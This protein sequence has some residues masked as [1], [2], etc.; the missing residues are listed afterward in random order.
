MKFS[1]KTKLILFALLITLN[2]IL[3]YQLVHHETGIDSFEMHIL[4]NSISEFGEARWWTNPFAIVG[5]H[6][7]SYASAISFTISGIS[8]CSDIDIELSILVYSIIL[9]IFSIFA[10]YILA[11]MLYDD[12][13]FKF[14]IAFGFSTCQG[15]LTYSTWTAN[16]RS[17]FVIL[18]PLFLYALWQ[19]R[20]N[21]LRFGL[22]TVS[23]TLLLFTTHHLFVYLM[24]VF[25][26]YF[27]VVV[28]YELAKHIRF[29]KIPEELMPFLIIFA[30]CLMFAYPFI[31]HK[32][33]TADSRWV[34][35]TF[36]LNEYP[37]YIGILVFLLPGG[38][39]YLISKPNKQFEEWSLLVMLMFLTVFV[40]EERYMKWFIIIFVILLTGIGL[41]NLK[42]L[43]ERRKKCAAIAVTIFL[44]LSVCFSGYFQFLHTYRAE[45][46][47]DENSYITAL[48]TKGKM[49]GVGICNSR[50]RAWKITAISALPLLTGSSTADQAYGLVDVREFQL[51][52]LPITSEEF[53]RDSP[54]KRVKGTVSD[55]YWQLIMKHY[56]TSKGYQWIP[57]F[58]ITYLIE[59]AGLHGHWA[60]HHGH[61]SSPFVKVVYDT[62]NCIYDSGKLK[63]WNLK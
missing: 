16:A 3:R 26:A 31:T 11:G 50:W 4:A 17:P 28:A 21:F 10:S 60:S 48:W 30:F 49:D 42:R 54:Y 5:M 41:M 24:P 36:M 13:F 38:Y 35:L 63:V 15:I 23:I 25:A 62:K 40:F 52:K 57:R 1:N 18:L 12:D 14:I 44:L 7:N 47:I 34:N 22:I 58:N 53:W 6:P 27:T 32:F 39:A 2:L 9:G 43:G 51:V 56:Y 37:R 19:S 33:M 45:K 55:G 29:I 46:T 61:G 20:K 59:E 8:Q